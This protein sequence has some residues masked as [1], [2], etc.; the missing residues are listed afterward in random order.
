MEE[1]S[2]EWFEIVLGVIK[3]LLAHILKDP[4]LLKNTHW[5]TFKLGCVISVIF[6]HCFKSFTNIE[7]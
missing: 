7:A 6:Y 2:K 1:T 5:S 4:N 3:V